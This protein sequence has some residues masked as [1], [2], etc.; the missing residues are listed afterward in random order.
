MSRLIYRTRVT[1]P[2][3]PGRPGDL[4]RGHI[5]PAERR[6]AGP[7]GHDR[8]RRQAPRRPPPRASPRI[9]GPSRRISMAELP[10]HDQIRAAAACT[11]SPAVS[12]PTGRIASSRRSASQR[13]AKVRQRPRSIWSTPAVRMQARQ[14]LLQF[15]PAPSPIR[16][17]AGLPVRPTSPPK[18]A[19]PTANLAL[20]P[21][22]SLAP[23]S[24]SAV[25]RPASHRAHLAARPATKTVPGERPG[26]QLVSR[27]NR[28]WSARTERR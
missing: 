19:R 24:L 21:R 12:M 14:L 17:R 28:P 3:R 9:P 15:G 25:P 22:R 10:S 8:Q 23:R 1:F 18:P 20:R 6:R 27:R 13:S 7:T 2:G 26:E 16:V 5:P 4:A 11:P